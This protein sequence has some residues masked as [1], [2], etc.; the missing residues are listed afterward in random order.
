MYYCWLYEGP[1]WKTKLYAGGALVLILAVVFFPIW[2]YKLRLGVWYLSMACLGLL[3]LFFAMAIFRLIL[4]VITMFA[5]PP[6]LWLF[7]NLFEDVG[8]FDSFKPTWAWQETAQ[9]KKE[10]KASKKAKKQAREERK[11]AAGHDHDEGVHKEDISAPVGV[12]AQAS[13]AEVVQPSA[14]QRVPQ[15][16]R[17]EEVEDDE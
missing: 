2:P 11:A 7:P 16:P 14:H 15:Q 8:F 5:A 3:G 10:A 1:Q 9:S 13:G 17:V 12:S 6:G 4:F